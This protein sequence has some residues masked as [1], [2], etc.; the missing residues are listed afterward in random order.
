MIW[1]C[2]P[3]TAGCNFLTDKQYADDLA[4]EESIMP[5]FKGSA[6]NARDMVAYLASL[7]G[8]TAGARK[9]G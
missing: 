2:R 5:P 1:N 4:G 9:V 8:G 6:R 3:W 7:G